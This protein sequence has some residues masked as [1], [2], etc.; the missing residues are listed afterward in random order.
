MKTAKHNGQTCY[1]SE[2][3]HSYFVGDQK[4]LSVTQFK[5]GFFPEFEKEKVAKKYAE[6]NGLAVGEVLAVWDERGRIGREK[7]HVLHAYAEA[8]MVPF[9]DPVDVPGCWDG[10]KRSIDLAVA[11]LTERYEFL[12][13]E[14]I[15]FSTK[16]GLAGQIDLLMRNGL[17]CLIWDWKT[18]NKIEQ[19][20][21]WRNALSPI[22]HLTDC[23]FEEYSIQLNI[24]QKILT[25][26]QYFPKG[27]KYRMG[28]CHLTE[29]GPQ[30]IKVDDMQSEIRSMLEWI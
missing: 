9:A 22:D 30:W 26:E 2:K 20:N 17:D 15:V 28:L 29:N 27:T 8:Q 18:D 16:L 21:P 6:K 3:D 4:L 24:Y 23:N 14:M 12:N 7:G 13:A 19:F 10:Q 5:G 25:E 1:F 11:R